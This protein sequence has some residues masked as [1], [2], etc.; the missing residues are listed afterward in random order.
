MQ[1]NVGSMFPTAGSGSRLVLSVFPNPSPFTWL[2]PDVCF[3]S[4][5]K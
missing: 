1:A 2:S 4:P 3:S 5:A